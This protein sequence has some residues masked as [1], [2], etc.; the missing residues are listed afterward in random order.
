M[1]ILTLRAGMTTSTAKE[2]IEEVPTLRAGSGF[3]RDIQGLR[4][5][6]VAL[7]VAN[8]LLSWPGGGYIGVDVFFVI[9]G[10]LI[11]GNLFREY[12][13]TGWISISSFYARRLRRIMPVAL[14]VAL[15]TIIVAY[16]VW[17]SPRANQTLLDGLASIFW[18]SNWHFAGLG[19]D[20]LAGSGP[21]SPFQ[22]YWSLSVEEQFYVFMPWL[23]LLLAWMGSRM[24]I[25][26]GARIVGLGI[27]MFGLTS[28]GWALFMTESHPAI[29]YFDTVS[30][31]W[32][33]VAGAMVAV[34]GRRLTVPNEKRRGVLQAV[35]LTLICLGALLLTTKSSFPAPWAAL[36]TVGAVMVII[37][38]IGAERTSRVLGN[39][40]AQYI[41]RISYSLYLWHFPVI[42]YFG[43]F[44]PG[45]NLAASAAALVLMFVLSDL[46]YRYVE[47]P[48][49]LSPF[50]RSWEKRPNVLDGR[51]KNRQVALGS[52]I[53]IVVLV[54]SVL[55]LKGP[56][57]F[58]NAAALMPSKSLAMD[59][60]RNS[61]GTPDPAYCVYGDPDSAEKILVLGDSV[62]VSWIPTVAE[63]SPTSATTG[64][65][66]AN[67]SAFLID[68]L[69]RVKTSSFVA[70]CAREKERMFRVAQELQPDVIVLSGDQGGYERQADG[71][72][73]VAAEVNWQRAVA[74]TVERF[75]ST[76]AA[77]VVLPSPPLGA[78]VRTCSSRFQNYDNCNSTVT[79]I[80]EAKTNAE[81]TAASETGAVFVDVADWFCG[82][83]RVC[84][85]VFGST[86]ARSDQTHITEEMAKLLGS[87]L[88]SVWS[89]FG[90]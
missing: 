17:F 43:V 51:W 83:D 33:F 42:V 39:P 29:A 37:G 86:I 85:A 45:T 5:F 71:S 16:I 78:D 34:A 58:S 19:A 11:T 48:G 87:R 77:V 21:V 40:T 1:V 23:I 41:G 65:G 81:R 50:L 80:W 90:R 9:S 73:G 22:H 6:A 67:C 70:D 31:S 24:R 35:G 36:P 82:P 79:A 89:P 74:R 75:A 7:V 59:Q 68:T 28:L 72:A 47:T 13:S 27:G 2:H 8:H 56:A 20:Y 62:A 32:E 30:R 88:A 60:C 44:Y 64:L 46:S 26:S 3:R 84:P 38:G 49:R 55:Q 12:Q 66:F 18:V 76:G 52:L 4:A 25:T 57:G 63:A 61:L 14:V 53:A 69:P 54:L 10:Y 15:V